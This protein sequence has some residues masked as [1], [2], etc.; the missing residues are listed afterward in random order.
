MER[1]KEDKRK[2]ERKS[3]E[4]GGENKVGGGMGL[5]RGGMIK[6]KKRAEQ[7]AGAVTP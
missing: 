1:R 2:K 7:V 3:R 5:G 6:E 4:G